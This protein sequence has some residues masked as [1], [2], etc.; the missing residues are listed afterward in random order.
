MSTETD[1]DTNVDRTATTSGNGDPDVDDQHDRAGEQDGTADEN[2][3][4]TRFYGYT[5]NSDPLFKD[6]PPPIS[7][8]TSEQLFDRYLSDPGVC[9][10][11]FR[12]V[13]R[14]YPEYDRES[15]NY[16]RDENYATFLSKGHR[17]I[18]KDEDAPEW[19]DAPIQVN[20]ASRA[21]DPGVFRDIVPPERVVKEDRATGD[22][23]LTPQVEKPAMPKTVCECG[24]IDIGN[25]VRPTEVKEDAVRHL[26]QLIRGDGMAFATDRAIEY[27]HLVRSEKPDT[28]SRDQEV[29]SG[30]IL[31]G[32]RFADASDANTSAGA[33]TG[34]D[35]TPTEHTETSTEGATEDNQE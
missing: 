15:A 6:G 18:E 24:V 29:L 34:A 5:R 23:R 9:S 19:E 16:L 17:E 14:Y 11:C 30:A 35:T 31:A 20:T 22:K 13:Y 28:Y 32:R 26:G 3:V 33:N 27:V 10:W 2:G 7:Y 4:Q 12:R 1:H 8:K 25:D 21:P